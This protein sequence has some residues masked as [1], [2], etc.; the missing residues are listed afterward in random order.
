[1]LSR[2]L[3]AL[4]ED[5]EVRGNLHLS[6]CYIDGTFVMTKKGESRR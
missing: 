6:E 4:T 1:M 2:I 3:D 5:L